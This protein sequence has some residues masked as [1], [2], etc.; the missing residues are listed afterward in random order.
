MWFGYFRNLE[1]NHDSYFIDR[2]KLFRLKAP[3]SR[4]IYC[5]NISTIN[6][7]KNETNI[8]IEISATNT[9]L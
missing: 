8:I 7:K 1:I 6:L 9:T 3:E 2:L 4:F 5:F